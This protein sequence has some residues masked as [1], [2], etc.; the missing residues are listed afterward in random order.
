MEDFFF[1]F[2]LVL[3]FALVI[4]YAAAN[5]FYAIA[6]M[7]GHNDRKYFWWCFACLPVGALMVIALPDRKRGAGSTSKPDEPRK[8]ASDPRK[9]IAQDLRSMHRL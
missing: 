4:G 6:C 1:I 3:I 8:N 2:V 5:T 9:Y 7:K